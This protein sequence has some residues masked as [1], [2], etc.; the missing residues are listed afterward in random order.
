MSYPTQPAF[1][2]T[3]TWDD[4]TRKHECMKWMQVYSPP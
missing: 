2:H 1:I 3:G 4:E